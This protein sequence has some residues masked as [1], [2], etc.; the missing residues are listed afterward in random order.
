MRIGKA[1]AVWKLFY[2][3]QVL[4]REKFFWEIPRPKK[5]YLLPKVLS[6]TEL[7]RLFN[8]ATFLKH[9][10]ILFTA[11]SAGLRVSEIVNL[12]WKH[13]DKNRGQILIEQAKGKK[14]RYVTLSTVLEDILI[15]YYKKSKVKP[16][17]SQENNPQN[18]MYEL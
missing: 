18:F 14:D 8:A 7:S 2:C 6:E 11:Y 16:L 15:S 3:K 12:K 17:I 9:K 5:P 13:L 4:K 10:A 1:K